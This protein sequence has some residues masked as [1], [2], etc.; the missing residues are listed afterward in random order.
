[1]RIH[2]RL[3][4]RRLRSQLILGI[5][6]VHLLLMSVFVVDMIARQYKFLHHQSRQ[7]ALSLANELA[8]AANTHVL[9]NDFDGLERVIQN[10]KNFPDLKYA[11][12]LAP[13]NEVLSHTDLSYVGKTALDSVSRRIGKEPGSHI[14]LADDE[15]V[16]AVAPVTQAG[17]TI[18]WARV[19][20]SQDYIYSHLTAILRNGV[21]YIL[22]A[23]AI[24]T[25]VGILMGNRLTRGLYKLV[26]AAEKIRAGDRNL[27]AADSDSFEVGRLAVAFNQMLDDIDARGS[28]LESIFQNNEGAIG[29]YDKDLRYVLFNRQFA[30]N[31]YKMTGK[32]PVAGEPLYSDFPSEVIEQRR[33]LVQNVLK[34]KKE[35]VEANYLID[36]KRAY[37]RTSF[38]PVLV[39][40]EIT[41]VTTNTINLTAIKEAEAELKESEEKFRTLV[42]QSQVGVYIL[43]DSRFVYVNPLI[44]R[45][46]G[47]SA[48]ELM[49]MERFDEIVHKEDRQLSTSKYENRL[50]GKAPTD[51][52]V[53]RVVKKDGSIA[54]IQTIASRIIY[55]NEMAVLGSVID[56]TDKLQENN[57]LNK[58]VIDAQEKERIQ[59]GMELH[60]NVQQILAGA[61]LTLD[62]VFGSY[63]DRTEALNALRDIKQYLS[64]GM[65]ELR[66]I[67][68]QLAPSIRWEQNL[69][70]KIRALVE[71]MNIGRSADV[72]LEIDQFGQPLSQEIQ[73]AFYRILQEQLTNILKYAHASLIS[74]RLEKMERMITLSIKDNGQGFD[75]ATKQSGIGLENIRR[76]VAALEGE[77]KIVSSVGNGCELLLQVPS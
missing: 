25:L 60:D 72:K 65:A 40:G 27:R 10:Y 71:T 44:E 61:M 29:L 38:N 20:I 22:A 41:G 4:P 18:A 5:A 46:S 54:Y 42:E 1:M 57:R 43:Q 75:P 23:I 21:F 17:A 62:F 33:A 24:G 58:A 14:L 19:A 15:I 32:F 52:Y 53:L 64:D 67:S 16:D 55:R 7:Q 77:M 30:E 28:I 47:Y 73:L 49:R 8:V 51:D 56:I 26:A 35:V 12:I 50:D 3:W 48:A 39:D 70:D 63:D 74:I 34:G 68:H 59:I 31:H 69:E 36:G 9:G 13:D 2:R 11:M 45:I 66:R 76:R 37:Y 6:L